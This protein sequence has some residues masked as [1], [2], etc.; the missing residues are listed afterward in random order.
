MEAPKVLPRGEISE[1]LRSHP[2]T[3]VSVAEG[4]CL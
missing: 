3:R 2:K 1:G 4:E